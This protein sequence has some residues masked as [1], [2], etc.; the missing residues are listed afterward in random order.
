MS[1]YAAPKKKVELSVGMYVDYHPKHGSVE[2]GRIVSWNDAWVFV[3]F[4]E[5]DS[6]PKACYRSSLT[7]AG[8]HKRL[9]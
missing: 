4:G 1:H 7:A 8:G 5:P 9:G 6:T 3:R 2:R